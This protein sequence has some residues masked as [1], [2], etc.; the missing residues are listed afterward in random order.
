MSSTSTI[1][2]INLILQK[3]LNLR[4][5]TLEQVSQY[6]NISLPNSMTSA[7][8]FTGQII[9]YLLGASAHSKPLPD[10]P[11]LNLEIKTIPI[12]LQQ[13][14]LETTYVCTAP[15]LPKQ[16]NYSFEASIL[17]NKLQHVLWLPIIIPNPKAD[18]LPK[19]IIGNA[20]L[21]RPNSIQLGLLRADW[22]ELSEMLMLGNVEELSSHF[23][24]VVQVRPKAANSSV[25]TAATSQDGESIQTLPRGFYLRKDFTQQILNNH[26]N[27]QKII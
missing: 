24:Q 1:D 11:E 8:G 17:Y 22:L 25:L 16:D 9:E 26:L 13:Q 19:R 5:Y 2:Q 14:V 20:F 3:A 21:W 23:G 15:M 10:F 18:I 4:G 12:N 7:K 6:L 27:N